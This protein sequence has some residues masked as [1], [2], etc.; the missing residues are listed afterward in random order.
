MRKCRFILISTQLSGIYCLKGY[1]IYIKS[2]QGV[3]VVHKVFNLLI[4]IIPELNCLVSSVYSLFYRGG[5]VNSMKYI[6]TGKLE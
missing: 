4:K 3:T 5:L 6:K 2:L 1:S